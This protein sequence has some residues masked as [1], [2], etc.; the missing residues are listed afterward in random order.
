MKLLITA[1]TLVALA[2]TAAAQ[3]SKPATA[4]ASATPAAPAASGAT[5]QQSKMKTCNAN[6]KTQGLKGDERKKF[7]KECLSKKPA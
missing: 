7:M 3:G 4:A 2:G 1:V 6:A 5:A